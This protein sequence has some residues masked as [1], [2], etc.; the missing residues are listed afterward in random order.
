MIDYHLPT[1]KLNE[2]RNLHRHTRNKREADR[3][4]AVVLLATGWTAE[5]VAEVLQVDPNTVR[6]HF[7]RYQQGGIELLVHIA[8]RGSEC[9]LDDIELALLNNHLQENLY[10]TAKEIAH[11][12]ENTFEVTYT[13]SGMTA[14]LHRLGYVY[15]KPKLI[16]GKADPEAQKEFLVEYEKVKE[17][18]GEED[19]IYFMDAVHPQHNPVISNAW[20]KRGDE[21]EIRSNTGRKRININGAM[22][23][24]KLEPVVRYDDTINS[25]S[26]IALLKQLE[27]LHPTAAVIYVICDNARYNRSKAVSKYLETSRIKLMFLPPYAPNLNL[28]ERLWKFFKKKILYNRYFESFDDF[29]FACQSF[30]SNAN[31]YHDEILSLM[32]DKFTIIG[33]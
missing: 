15:K 6:N 5:Q 29:K 18:K 23:L 20:I 27:Q 32:S 12:V 33:D 4:K 1:D 10:L 13:E 11:W 3:I 30:F 24:D 9:L 25:E 28:I 8:F 2:L 17:N 26:T 21:Q 7:K 19:P 31:Q 14:L 22:S 16:P